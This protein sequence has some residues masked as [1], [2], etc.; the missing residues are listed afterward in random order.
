LASLLFAVHP[1]SAQA[2]A[3][4]PGG[5]DPLATIFIVSAFIFFI[6]YFIPCR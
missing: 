4:I 1:V 3:W 5:N 6:N 2:V